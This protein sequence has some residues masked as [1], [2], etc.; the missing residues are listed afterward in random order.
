MEAEFASLGSA[1][2][3]EVSVE[4]RGRWWEADPATPWLE[5]AEE[6]IA[7]EWGTR[8]LYVREGG[9]MPVSPVQGGKMGGGAHLPQPTE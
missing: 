2:R 7:R 5:L 6:A 8:P 4:A 3:L 9:T 1:N